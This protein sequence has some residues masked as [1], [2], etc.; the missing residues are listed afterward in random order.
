[1]DKFNE[2]RLLVKIASLYYEHDLNQSAIAQ[3]LHLSQSFVSRALRR[4]N[5][6]GIVRFSIAHPTGTHI[7]LENDLQ[8]R[9]LIDQV[10]IVDVEDSA[11][12]KTIK[13]AIA[14]AAVAYLESTLRGDEL[15]GLSSWSSFISAMVEQIHHKT[16]SAQGVIQILGGV[17][18]NENLQ[19][20]MVTNDLARLL[21][22]K[23]YLLPTKSFGRNPDYKPTQL[24]NDEL[25][26]VVKLFPNVDV[27]IVGIGAKEPSDLVRK[28]GIFYREETKTELTSKHA[29]GDL[30]LHYYDRKGQA[31]LSEEDD[32]VISMSLAQ[33]KACNNVVAL[34][35]GLHKVDAILGAL[36]GGYLD[37]LIT[38]CLTAQKMMDG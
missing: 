26:Q 36:A 38:D 19:A 13:R 5:T 16:A 17:G 33:L 3:R 22:C 10:I 11:T 27:A 35:G 1:M 24:E 34:A 18:H 31:I 12:E 23:A 14:S 32:P 8:E 4:C 25:E 21:D 30:C 9:Y 37:V 2:T 6:E 7:T 28:A 20:N 15:I 29:V